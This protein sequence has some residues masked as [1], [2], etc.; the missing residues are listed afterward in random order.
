MLG[1]LRSRLTFAN[2]VS[3]IALFVALGGTGYAAVKL[4]RNSVGTTQLKSNAVTSGKVKNGA[5]RRADF[6]AGDL[7]AGE[8]GPA[9]TNGTNGTNGAKG[10][11]G[12]QGLS[13]GPVA[14]ARVGADGTLEPSTTPVAQSKGVDQAD[15][16]HNPG[17]VPSATNTGDG[18]YCFG[19]LDFPVANAVVTAGNADTLANGNFDRFATVAVQRGQSLGR[20]DTNHQQVRV[21]IVDR[22][23]ATNFG[24]V[25][26]PFY[27]WFT[28]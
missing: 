19:G 8:R 26:H 11:K 6:R 5:L 9:G 24:L 28:N 13:G 27:I 1:R 23:E 4:P 10:D 18:T 25:D 16:Q 17:G 22:N 12:D 3:L 2:T 15:I 14:Y 7:P 20:C 21:V